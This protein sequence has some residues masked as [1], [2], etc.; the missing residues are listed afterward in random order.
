MTRE[1][2]LS[3]S[4]QS[5]SWN[6][7]PTSTKMT[8]SS[9]SSSSSSSTS[10]SSL[11][12]FGLLL[13]TLVFQQPKESSAEKPTEQVEAVAGWTAS[14]PCRVQ[15]DNTPLLVLWYRQG[16]AR[17]FYCFDGRVGNLSAGEG[18]VLDHVFGP[19]STFE[20]S[21][22]LH[23][24][25]YSFDLGRD[26]GFSRT[27]VQDLREIGPER[28]RR[29]R[30]KRWD[31]W[32]EKEEGG[33]RGEGVGERGIEGGRGGGGK[34]EEGVQEDVLAEEVVKDSVQKREYYLEPRFSNEV[35]SPGEN[36]V[37]KIPEEGDS[38]MAK[39]IVG[40]TEGEGDLQEDQWTRQV[41]EVDFKTLPVFP[42][43]LYIRNVSLEDAGGFICR[44]EFLNSP[45]HKHSLNLTVY[46]PPQRIS[47]VDA[48]GKHLQA[49]DSGEGLV[50]GPLDQDASLLVVCNVF[51]G[52][53]PPT[54]QWLKNGKVVKD[55]VTRSGGDGNWSNRLYVQ[56]LKPE[57][58]KSVFSCRVSNN[59]IMQPSITNVTLD[60]NIKPSSVR[61]SGLS[62]PMAAGSLAEVTCTASGSRPHAVITW[63][64]GSG[65]KWKPIHT[66]QSHTVTG[67]TVSSVLWTVRASDDKLRLTCV[68]T[69]PR[70]PQYQR[71]NSTVLTVHHAPETH[72]S[73]GR[74][75]DPKTIKMGIDVYFDCHVKANPPPTST[76]F[77]H[78][79]VQV[80]KKS[81]PEAILSGF[82]L[83]LQKVTPAMAGE[84][85]CR[86]TNSKGSSTS[87]VVNLEVL[88]QP[89][90]RTPDQNVSVGLGR[91]VTVKCTVD[92]FPLPSKF[93][94]SVND[95]KGVVSLPQM[96]F[97]SRGD[98]SH[99]NYSMPE[100]VQVV[101][102]YCWANNSLGVQEAPCIFRVLA[103]GKPKQ[104]QECTMEQRKQSLVVSC[105]PGS[106]EA[107]DLTYQAQ[108]R[109][110]DSDEVIANVTSNAPSF[111]FDM[112][113]KGLEYE[114]YVFTLNIRYKS[115]PVVL[116]VSSLKVAE[117][118]MNSGDPDGPGDASPMLA[119]FIGVITAFLLTLAA[120][121]AATKLRCS[122]TAAAG[123]AKAA[124]AGGVSGE[125]GGSI[126]G[127]EDNGDSDDDDDDDEVSKDKTASKD[128]QTT[129]AVQVEAQPGSRSKD[130]VG[131]S[132]QDQLLQGTATS[133]GML[134]KDPL[135]SRD[136]LRQADDA[137][138]YKNVSFDE[139][140]TKGYSVL[141]TSDHTLGSPFASLSSSQFGVAYSGE[142]VGL[143]SPN[144]SG[145]HFAMGPM[146]LLYGT[147][148]HPRSLLPQYHTHSLGRRSRLLRETGARSDYFGGAR[149]MQ[150][151]ASFVTPHPGV[152]STVLPPAG[153]RVPGPAGS[154][155]MEVN[156]R[157]LTPL[158][159]G[160]GSSSGGG[161]GGGEGE[162]GG[163]GGGEVGPTETGPS[164]VRS[165]YRG[166]NEGGVSMT[167]VPL[168]TTQGRSSRYH[169]LAS[170]PAAG[171]MA[172]TTTISAR[173]ANESFV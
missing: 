3:R 140:Y 164:G 118:R 172:T 26:F 27:S 143:L 121:L 99:L 129:R 2:D 168:T 158:T 141:G 41:D 94:W 64:L 25:K 111:S 130:N 119:L 120:I 89:V 123:A 62:G 79:G 114:V 97:V 12:P 102:L 147:L 124:R 107:V 112:L 14:L 58:Q 148:G 154:S 22:G 77:F 60:M 48:H 167:R 83:V 109:L 36:E 34:P 33:G 13:L 170:A 49:Q 81:F 131:A 149:R 52:S 95:T 6:S 63:S 24:P 150:T 69:N 161:G 105:Q 101:E 92:A 85:S 10:S 16:H 106:D 146:P 68:A 5:R 38:E 82:F 93:A 35:S 29:R 116:E 156:V 171:S 122:A 90:C 104:V 117:N 136:A 23:L 73:L 44:V 51:G 37:K 98:T 80:T 173:R 59:N 17:P 11:R 152:S 8:S 30:K 7:L 20:F 66:T 169:T 113:E 61:L 127:L 39:Y 76:V 137:T 31:D 18:I 134:Q 110:S 115:P 45:T 42:G 50:L 139:G 100:N 88:Y 70:N 159:P 40:G 96:Q 163:G 155:M 160:V 1:H 43:T 165:Q 135:L 32:T 28:R 56:K 128:D 78:K 54:I 75:L 72:L 47:I 86:A 84:Y 67:D 108:L 126:I 144:S 65:V 91:N 71:S 46:D 153:V 55:E 157:G 15:N 9:S 166:W 138:V 87:E 142:T 53:P 21:G 133:F 74:G 19:R 132:S 103:P 125:A 57:D 162:R 145:S 4:G 151:S